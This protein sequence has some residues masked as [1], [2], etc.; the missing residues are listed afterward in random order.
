M[1]SKSGPCLVFQARIEGSTEVGDS[2]WDD[3]EDG[4][5]VECWLS[6]PPKDHLTPLFFLLEG[7][8][9]SER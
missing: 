5:G 6:P 9:L 4:R 8:W 2:T 3:Q 1:L 7:K